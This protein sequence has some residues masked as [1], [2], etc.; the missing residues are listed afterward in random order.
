MNIQ[1]SNIIKVVA[2]HYGVSRMDILSDRRDAGIVHARMVSYWL[3]KELT[4]HSYPVIGGR[5][6]RDHTTIMN[7]VRIIEAKRGQ[8]DQLQADLHELINRLDN[9]ALPLPELVRS[10]KF[11][12]PA[13]LAEA[14]KKTALATGGTWSPIHEKFGDHL[15]VIDLYG[16][17]ASGFGETEACHHWRSIALKITKAQAA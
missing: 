7:G 15:F 14:L 8:D 3:A 17:N 16:I 1:I 2:A 12:A 5:M 10:I 9:L 6:N 4:P 11:M 13:Q